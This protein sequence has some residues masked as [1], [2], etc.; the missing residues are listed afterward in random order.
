MALCTENN[1]FS[2]QQSGAHAGY[3]DPWREGGGGGGG[4][5]MGGVEVYGA[6]GM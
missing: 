1:N 6:P 5:E 4:G 2:K 3:T